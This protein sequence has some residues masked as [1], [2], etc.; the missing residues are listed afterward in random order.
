MNDELFFKALLMDNDD[1]HKMMSTHV[2]CHIKCADLMTIV[3]LLCMLA[4]DEDDA[5]ELRFK[6]GV[7]LSDIK[8][9]IE[10]FNEKIKCHMER[11]LNQ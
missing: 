9:L 4:S 8:E 5:M 10:E 7:K 11:S 2:K 6:M 1:F 3:S